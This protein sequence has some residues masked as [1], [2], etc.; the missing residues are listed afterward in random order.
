MGRYKWLVPVQ[1]PVPGTHQDV[2]EVGVHEPQLGG[3][4][5]TSH[6]WLARVEEEC[7][8]QGCL[9]VQP[10]AGGYAPGTGTSQSHP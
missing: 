8:Y 1:A 9:P 4:W 6:S 10:G 3:C 7:G 5:D 2:L